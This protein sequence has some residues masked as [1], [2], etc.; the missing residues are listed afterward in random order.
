[1]K[2]QNLILTVLISSSSILAYSQKTYNGLPVIEANNAKI[3]YYVNNIENSNWTVTPKV[4]DDTLLI[5]TYLSEK[6]KILFKFKTD[7]DSIK[8]EIKNDEAKRFYVHLNNES[9]AL[10][11]VRRQKIFIPTLN[12]A[13]TK[14][15]PKYKILYTNENEKEYLNSLNSKYPIPF[16]NS[17]T[18]IDKVLTILNWTRSQWEHRGD[19]SPKKNDAIS[20]L[21][22][23]KEGGRFPCFAYGYVLASQLKVS[24]FKSRVIYLKTSDIAT[25]MRGG[26]HVA[27]E[28]FIDELQKWVFVDAQFNAMPFLN[29]VPLN[30]VEFQN[31]IRTNFDKL[32]FKSLGNVDKMSYISF[33]QPYLYYF[34]CSFDQREA[35]ITERNRVN[36][37]RSL[38]LVPLATENPTFMLVWNSKIDYCEYT[39]SINDFYAKPN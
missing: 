16:K 33:V 30:A 25:S 12:Y 8:F 29:N 32:E 1:M 3:K 4:A 13:S 18:Q 38:M 7:I 34:D 5:K 2:L 37:K 27:T 35:V 24:G 28:V 31:A 39:N 21:D 17:K 14:S 23:V 15:N 22:E 6:T 19:V 36:N 10:T 26:G 9:Y 20:I 11:T